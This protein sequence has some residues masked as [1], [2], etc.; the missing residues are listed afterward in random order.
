MNNKIIF[1]QIDDRK[2]K[3]LE[4]INLACLPVVY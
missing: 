2:I 1:D 4:L 3:Q